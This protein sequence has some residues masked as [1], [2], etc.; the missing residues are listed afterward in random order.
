MHRPLAE[1]L[2]Q[3][4][5]GGELARISVE[6]DPVLEISEIT[7]RVAHSGGPALLFE[8]VRGCH[9][10]VLTNLLGSP[11]RVCRALRVQ[12]LDELTDRVRLALWPP[13]ETWV[14]RLKLASH[15]PALS[16]LRP[17]VVKTGACQ[18][19]V[20]LGRDVDLGELP[21]LHAWPGDAGRT[22]ASGRLFCRSPE[23][24]G[25]DAGDYFLQA[26]DAARLG[27][28]WHRLQPGPRVLAEHAARGQRMPV[29]VT[30]GGDPLDAFLSGA[31]LPEQVDAT[32]WGGVLR[33][34]PM[35]LVKCRTQELDVPAD[36]EIVLEGFIDPAAAP[37]TV[38]P[39][40]GPDGFEAPAQP[41]PA[42]QLTAI[43]HRSNPLYVAS[44]PGRPPH[45]L[46]WI[47]QAVER[48]SLPTV[49]AAVPELV[50]YALPTF[51]APRALVF[52]SIR[53]RYPQ[54]ARKAAAALWGLE[55]LM[56]CRTMVLVDEDVDVHDAERVLFEVGAHVDPS[57]DLLLHSGPADLWDHTAAL[58]LQGHHLAIDATRKWPEERARPPAPPLSMTPEVRDLVSGRWSS[59]GL[60]QRE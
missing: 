47:R 16:S 43:T 3:L 48:A 23:T 19:V 46:A 9:L 11:Q 17:K 2:E 56:L 6:V 34:R 57:R 30:L 13:D 18:Q 45:E 1:F 22:I 12:R 32:L 40:A 50:D 37:V 20:R 28:H 59:Y 54:H 58:P 51:V 29:A 33:G 4:D 21:L 27:V 36:A 8:N 7:S 49:Q 24:G 53:K 55:H 52:V 35:E 14:D 42:V 41:G 10:P 26:L 31:A 25:Y 60:P 38:G 15:A 39:L 44:V 5:E